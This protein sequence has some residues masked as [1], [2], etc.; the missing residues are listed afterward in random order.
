MGIRHDKYVKR[1][2]KMGAKYVVYMLH[3]KHRHHCYPPKPKSFHASSSF[4]HCHIAAKMLTIPFAVVHMC[5]IFPPCSNHDVSGAHVQ[6]GVCAGSSQDTFPSGQKTVKTW[7]T[8][9]LVVRQ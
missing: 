4:C 1:C 7:V 8:L 2:S 6:F 9:F 3:A 5:T